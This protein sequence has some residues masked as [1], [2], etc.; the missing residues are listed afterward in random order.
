[1]VTNSFDTHGMMHDM[2]SERDIR[3]LIAEKR[4]EVVRLNAYIDALGD[5][6]E[7]FYSG[8]VQADRFSPS[9]AFGPD[10]S[11]QAS[12]SAQ[13]AP[14]QIVNERG[15]GIHEPVRQT[16]LGPKPTVPERAEAYIRTKGQPAH[17]TEICQAL[18][19]DNSDSS[20]ASVT[21]SILRHV[22]RGLILKLGNGYYGLP[23]RDSGRSRNG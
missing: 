10:R 20:R 11:G 8:N 22:K 14:V 6:L 2:V 1:M 19:Y 9:T 15:S 3:V 5:L 16:P 13:P 12:V 21:G 7:R 4:A 23:G 17:I 18:G